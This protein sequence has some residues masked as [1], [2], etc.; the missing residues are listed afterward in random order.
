MELEEHDE[1]KRY[2]ILWGKKVLH[3]PCNTIKILQF[4]DIVIARL[5]C[6]LFH[7][8]LEKSDD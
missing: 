4:K 3:P 8:P 1:P 6:P 5:H 2:I 7:T